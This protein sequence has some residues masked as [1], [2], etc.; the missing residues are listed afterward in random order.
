MLDYETYCKIRDHHDRQGLSITQ[1][2]RAL[3]LHP[4]TVSKWVRITPYRPRR[5][6]A[7][8]SRLDPYKGLIVRW[9]DEHPL[10]AQQVFQRLLE[11][12]FTGGRT[13]VADY[14]RTIRPRRPAAFL[15]LSFAAGECAQVDWG[16]YGSIGVGS[17]R[18]RL[19][20]FVMVLCYSRLMYLQF[21]VS[22][23]MEHF[24]ACHEN[25]WSAFGG[26]VQRVMVDNLK[27]AVL[28]RLAGSAPVLNPRY[29]DYA[30]HAGFTIS[31][32]NVRAG[33]EKGRVESGVGYVKKNLLNG[34]ELA[35]FSAVN[36]TA[37][38]WLDSIANVRIH[39]ETHRRPVD[40]F[41]EERA[42]LRPLN[43]APYDLARIIST[44][45]SSQF[46][47]RLDTNRYSVPAEHA[48]ARVLVKAYPDRI[49]ICREHSI[50]ARHVRSYD[51]RADIEDPDHPKVLL[52]QRRN[53]REQRLLMQFLALSPQ[54][55]SYYEGLE[56]RRLNPRHHVRKILALAEIYGA[57]ATRRA[58]ADGL[59]FQAF[60]CEYIAHLLEARARSA[61]PVSPL[62]LTRRQDLLELELPE[63]DL[64]I[65]EVKD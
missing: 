44:R 62:S 4:Q 8:H 57:E 52:A 25:A 50:I 19:S 3:G 16:E 18:R 64:S 14:V 33:W 36:P 58:L 59:A 45:A 47:V 63:A 29:L 35:D 32:C 30:R 38:L 5:S 6:P 21:T 49:V 28:Q 65:Y 26:V 43:S 48:G 24:L 53:A 17:T 54:A 12:G 56:N 13:I 34:L 37:Q 1:T 10:S 9:L 2:A 11:S 60:S 41:Q 42:K 7:P 31:A 40:L 23:T 20:F 46:R 27:S 51:R 39:G 55:Q 22:Q 15:R 61:P